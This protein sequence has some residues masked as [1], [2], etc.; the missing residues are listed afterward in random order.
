M[1]NSSFPQFTKQFLNLLFHYG[2]PFLKGLCIIGNC[3]VISRCIRLMD[4]ILSFL[5]NPKRMLMFLN[6]III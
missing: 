3:G 2:M 6:K 1:E 5:K 4:L